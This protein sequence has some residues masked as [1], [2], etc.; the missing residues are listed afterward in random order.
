MD[1]GLFDIVNRHQI[2]LEGLKR[3]KHRDFAA[4]VVALDT[5]IRDELSSMPFNTLSDMSKASLD[6]FVANF[7]KRMIGIYDP[8]LR[9]LLEWFE[10][11]IRADAGLFAEIYSAV[12]PDKA[13]VIEEEQKKDDGFWLPILARWKN[14]PLGA[15][16][17]LPINMLTTMIGGHV[18]Q[19]TNTLR[20]G[21]ALGWTAQETI[22]AMRGT[23]TNRDTLQGG[24]LNRFNAQAQATTNTITQAASVQANAAV[25]G[26]IF[27]E[28]EWVSILDDRTTKICRRLDGKHWVYGRGPLPPAHVGC[29]STIKPWEDGPLPDESFA[30]WARRQPS[31][32]RNDAFDREPTSSYE[33]AKPISLEEFR[34]KGSLI[35]AK[36]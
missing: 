3:G 16:G 19:A 5:L 6:K 33:G 17:V 13:E 23:P 35:L 7:R 15:N 1:Y 30:V 21:Y 22:A 2:Y 12:E 9:K 20:Q 28:Y 18:T 36:G 34:A 4:V 24:L 14:A 26:L 25:G 29:R 31:A 27:G 32:F 8:W 11:Y 10:E